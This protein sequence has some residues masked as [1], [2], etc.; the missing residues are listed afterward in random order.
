M[1]SLASK[2]P[3]PTLF[4]V[5][6]APSWRPLFVPPGIQKVRTG[7]TTPAELARL[8]E[9]APSIPVPEPRASAFSRLLAALGLIPA[10]A[11]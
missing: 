5:H 8:T 3:A 10:H 1:Q 7:R 2:R 6:S 11:R 4:L 9:D